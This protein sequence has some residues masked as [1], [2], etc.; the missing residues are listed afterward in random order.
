VITWDR[1]SG[2]VTG[3]HLAAL[4]N[5]PALLG[6]DAAVAA[7][8]TLTS[9]DPEP[10]ETAPMKLLLAALAAMLNQPALATADEATAVA[11]LQGWRPP[12]GG[13]ADALVAALGLTSGADE[14]AALSAIGALKSPSTRHRRVGGRIAAPSRGADRSAAGRPRAAGPSKTP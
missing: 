9:P 1:D 3:V 2:A 5:Y 13:R 14:A 4:T 11:A 7:L 6:M 10:P 8:S 12:E